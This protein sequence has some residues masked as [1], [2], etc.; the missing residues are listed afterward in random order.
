MPYV[1]ANGVRLYYEEHGSG[2]P[3][4]G[5]HGTSSSATMW[6]DVA[7]AKL[8]TLGRAIIYDRRGCTRSERPEPYETGVPEQAADA[9]ALLDALGASPAIVIGRSYGG[10]VGIELALRHPEHVRAL[11]ILEAAEIVDEE[12]SAWLDRVR[13]AI[14]AAG[15][16]DPST[17]PEELFRWIGAEDAW[18]A[19]PEPIRQM[20]TANAPAILAELRGPLL[21]VTPE[22]LGAIACPTLVVTGEDSLPFYARVTERLVDAIP[23]ASALVVE[24]GHLIDPGHPEIL[25]FIR[26]VLR[27]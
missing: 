11:A 25:G 17:V 10:D 24:G 26:D 12:A 22:D 19:F 18:P 20:I 8:A 27:R 16:R 15:E 13:A 14:A 7:S 4:L 1:Q 23:G 21:E 5:I 2:D 3:I 6:H 9:A